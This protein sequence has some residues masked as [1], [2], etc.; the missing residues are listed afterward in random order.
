MKKRSFQVEEAISGLLFSV[1]YRN[2]GECLVGEAWTSSCLNAHFLREQCLRITVIQ[3]LHPGPSLKWL[4]IT[5][6]HRHFTST[7]RNPASSTHTNGW[8]VPSRPNSLSLCTVQPQ[9][10][11]K[12]NH[13]EGEGPRHCL[14]SASL[15]SVW[16]IRQRNKCPSRVCCAKGT[17]IHSQH[18]CIYLELQSIPRHKA[19]VLRKPI[20][21]GETGS[22]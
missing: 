7:P 12:M 18:P 21:F 1:H 5:T 4:P 8:K 17:Q 2:T 3:E 13:N 16:I 20:W 19:F 9:S 15:G 11:V 6:G 10:Q 22:K 14:A